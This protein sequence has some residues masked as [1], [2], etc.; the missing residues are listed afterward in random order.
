MATIVAYTLPLLG[1]LC[2]F[3]PIMT[4]LQRR[5]H[6]VS[7]ALCSSERAL[8]TEYA[9]LPV[10]HV[11]WM[12]STRTSQGALPGPLSDAESFVEFVEHG[13]PLAN[14][15]E[16]VLGTHRP[17]VVL[18]DPMLWGGM[19]AAEAQTVKW[20]SIA[21]NPLL[22]RGLGTD[23]RGPALPPP[24][25]TVGRLRLRLAAMAKRF[26]DASQ[27]EQVNAVRLT[28]GLKP[29]A[30]FN[31]LY[32]TAPL[33]IATTAEPF[34]YP[35]LDWPPSLRFVGP[36]L[37]DPPTQQ[38]SWDTSDPR[39]LV[40]I[41]DS[42]LAASGPRASWAS[43]VLEAL[44]EEPYQVIA[45]LPTQSAPRSLPSNVRVLPHIPHSA[46]LPRAA[47]VL[48]HGGPG[49]TLKALAF[50]V[51]VVA[52][53]F[54]YDR[55]EVARRVEVAGAGVMLPLSKLA[56]RRIRAAVRRAMQSKAGALRIA[57][58][59]RAAGGAIAAANAIEDLSVPISPCTQLA[60]PT[61]PSWTRES[62]R[63]PHH[64]RVTN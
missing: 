53:P 47:C 34:E 59:F 60:P 51:P 58:A 14:G 29:L 62:D 15:L 39:P 21:H 38:L 19:V 32:L 57:S 11:Q 54:A 37:W 41:A 8:L 27:L 64:S 50:G 2:P 49:I 9:G 20:V 42:T 4:E 28:R 55:F 56:P 40:L 61:G 24:S 44:A 46:I 26:E 7:L 12:R 3:I 31:E 22:L 23:V 18:V 52:V 10:T 1:H 5:H 43:A 17:D 33:T 35:R 13:E 48:C 63:S 16:R 30:A 36:M 25:G 6:T 45:T